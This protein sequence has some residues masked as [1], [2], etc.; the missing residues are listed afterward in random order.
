ME[1]S[2]RPE[3]R[4]GA[5]GTEGGRKDRSSRKSS[6]L[7]AIRLI[8]QKEGNNERKKEIRER[9]GVEEH[10]NFEDSLQK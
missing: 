2:A 8:E 3:E 1:S 5:A 7:V 4:H 10:I 6:H 9:I